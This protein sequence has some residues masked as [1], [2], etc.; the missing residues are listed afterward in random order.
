MG[1]TLSK[2]YTIEDRIYEYMNH[3][4][5]VKNSPKYWYFRNP[6]LKFESVRESNKY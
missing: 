3:V 1:Y 5:I 6:S 4:K 2:L